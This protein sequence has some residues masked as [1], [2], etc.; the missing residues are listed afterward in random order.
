M[1]PDESSGSIAERLAEVRARLDAA[2]TAC[3]RHSD[4]VTL[5]AVTKGFPVEDAR[6]VFLAGA[7]E[8]GENRVQ[9]LVA[10][11]DVFRAAGL[12]PHWH[13]I[14]TL[15]KNKVRHVVGRVAMVHSV[16]GLDLL[17]EIS[18]RSVARDVVTDVLLQV[19]LS[20]EETKHG[21]D[22]TDIPAAVDIALGM[23]NI[24][25]RGLMTMAQPAE[26]PETVRPVFKGLAD[27]H[28]SLRTRLPSGIAESFDVLSMG[29]SHDF[30]VAIA[31]GATHVRIG[32]AIFGGRP[33]K[34]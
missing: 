19:N 27:L 8:L 10:K 12:E 9:E 4:S 32:T 6:E 22:E 28:A 3:G 26:D 14:G 25:L 15:Q 2:C 18:D 13:L 29:M 30:P 21:F 23:K 16:D 5:I 17:Q 20:H 31:C 33:P 7:V 34:A 24:R 1:N 11:A